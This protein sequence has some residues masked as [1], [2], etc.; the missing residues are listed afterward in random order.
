M[1]NSVYPLGQYNSVLATKAKGLMKDNN[2][3]NQL[4]FD[5]RINAFNKE[6][7]IFNLSLEKGFDGV[8]KG[9]AIWCG[10]GKNHSYCSPV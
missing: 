3:I 8:D 1:Q 7:D 9:P 10:P 2:D 5:P 4:N 6:I